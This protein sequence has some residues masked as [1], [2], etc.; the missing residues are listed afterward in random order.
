MA[1][2]IWSNEDLSHLTIIRKLRIDSQVLSELV[3][4]KVWK[5]YFEVEIGITPND[6]FGEDGPLNWLTHKTWISVEDMEADLYQN[7]GGGIPI[8]VL[9]E[10]AI[11]VAKR[12]LNSEDN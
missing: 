11:L 2:F 9:D 6:I 12:N 3:N 4:S 1:K 10:L 5:D 8:P 7:M